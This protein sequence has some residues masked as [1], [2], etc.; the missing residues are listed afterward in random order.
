MAILNLNINRREYEIAC[1]DG[2]EQ[3]LLNLSYELDKR[4]KELSRSINTGNQSLLLVVAAIQL[5]DELYEARTSGQGQVNI[6][7]EANKMNSAAI[8]YITSRIEDLAQRLERKA[9]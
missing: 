9:G 3:H 8:S 6:Q 1:T 5:L 2:E 4:V 7:D